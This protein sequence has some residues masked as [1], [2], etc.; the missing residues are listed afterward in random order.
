LYEK[1]QDAIYKSR[2]WTQEGIPS[3]E[4][5]KRLSIDFPEVMDLLNAHEVK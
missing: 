2:G 4:T 5:V 1:L 3:V